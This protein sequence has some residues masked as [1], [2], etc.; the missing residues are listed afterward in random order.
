M[1]LHKTKHWE[2]THNIRHPPNWTITPTDDTQWQYAIY[3]SKTSKQTLEAVTEQFTDYTLTTRN[4]HACIL[5][6]KHAPMLIT[7]TINEFY[8][9]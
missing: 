6:R 3:P 7:Q 1:G 4:N 5:A 8:K 2:S 9:P